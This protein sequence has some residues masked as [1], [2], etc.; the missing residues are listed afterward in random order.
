MTRSG[1][2]VVLVERAG[3]GLKWLVVGAAVGASLA[4]LFAPKSGKETRRELRKRLQGLKEI[5]D[6]TL[7]EFREVADESDDQG[8][9]A[10][11]DRSEAPAAESESGRRSSPKAAAREELERR[12][13]A[14]RGRR[15]HVG[16]DDDE[17][18]VA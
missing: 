13:T 17:E 12:L 9:E 10:A 18:P 5:A 6:E 3:G 4:L 14:A 1:R 15:R 7:D 16:P 8:L 11:S 2:E